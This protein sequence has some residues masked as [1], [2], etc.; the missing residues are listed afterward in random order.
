MLFHTYAV[1]NASTGVKNLQLFRYEFFVNFKKFRLFL[2]IFDVVVVGKFIYV[3][4]YYTLLLDYRLC[5][6]YN[7]IKY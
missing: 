4:A 1:Q 7:M 2:S 3:T 5:I 6:A